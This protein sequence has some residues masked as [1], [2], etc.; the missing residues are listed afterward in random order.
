[1]STENFRNR[2]NEKSLNEWNENKEDIEEH[3]KE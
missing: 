1:M 3:T 2:G